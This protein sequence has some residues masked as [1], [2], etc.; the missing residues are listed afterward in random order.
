[1]GPFT[2]TGTVSPNP[3]PPGG[4]IEVTGR[5]NLRAD[6]CRAVIRLPGGALDV[7]LE[8]GPEP[9][10]SLPRPWSGTA[11]LPAGTAPGRYEVVIT[12]VRGTLTAE[13]RLWLEVTDASEG[14]TFILTG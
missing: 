3:S 14:L 7:E 1:V 13:A 5:P 8:A 6:G 9:D 2:V 11:R 4:R 12:A 10:S